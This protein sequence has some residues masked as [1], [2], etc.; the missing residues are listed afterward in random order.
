MSCHFLFSFFYKEMLESYTIANVE[1]WN[2]KTYILLKYFKFICGF[3]A[4]FS[5]HSTFDNKQVAS[6]FELFK[7]RKEKNKWSLTT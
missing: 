3:F 5:F 4:L 1:M 2:E 6:F 7:K